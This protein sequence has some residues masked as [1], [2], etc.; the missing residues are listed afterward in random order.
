MRLFT[1]IKRFFCSH[2]RSVNMIEENYKT[3]RFIF[4]IKTSLIKYL[5]ICFRDLKIL[6]AFS[7]S[8]LFEKLLCLKGFAK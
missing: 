8:L 5:K 7:S 6:L 2:E 1:N 3:A 4:N